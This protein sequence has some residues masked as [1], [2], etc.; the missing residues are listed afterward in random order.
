MIQSR[1][2]K[3]PQAIPRVAGYAHYHRGRFP[4]VKRIP[5]ARRRRITH[6][7]LPT[8]G[9]LAAVSLIAGLLVGASADS[10]SERAASRFADAWQRGDYRA[11]HGLLTPASRSRH[12][13]PEFRRAYE[14]A[15]ATA[16][17][18]KIEAD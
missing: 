16:T 8:L 9:G 13:L 18:R 2:V 14:R 6:R 11:M 4:Y 17:V 12:P 7:A 3:A 1:P 10:A 15:A 5:P